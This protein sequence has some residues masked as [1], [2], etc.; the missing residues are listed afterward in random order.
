MKN[1]NMGTDLDHEDYLILMKWFEFK[2]ARDKPEKIPLA[3][4]RVF[5]KLTF[6]QE[7]KEEDDRLATDDTDEQC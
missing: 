7:Q 5:W 3:D 6:L 2:F 1:K 4:R